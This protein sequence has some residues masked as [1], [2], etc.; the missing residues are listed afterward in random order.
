MKYIRFFALLSISVLT[1]SGCR[2][3]EPADGKLPEGGTEV[4]IY[5]EEGRL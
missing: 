5:S 2:G 4:N 3:R 1:L